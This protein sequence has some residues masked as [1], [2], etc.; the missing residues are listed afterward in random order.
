MRGPRNHRAISASLELLMQLKITL[1]MPRPG[2]TES[3]SNLSLCSGG[4]PK[5]AATDWAPYVCT[6]SR[7][8]T[9][10]QLNQLIKYLLKIEGRAANHFEDLGSSGLL[11]Q[12]LLQLLRPL[13][14]SFLE[15]P[16]GY[17]EP[18]SRVPSHGGPSRAG[19]SLSK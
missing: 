4:W 13:F 12:R 9:S 16:A 14:D 11:L 2:R 5:A 1:N 8:Q 17:L 18:F 7:T 6:V 10:G 15:L 19:F 3:R